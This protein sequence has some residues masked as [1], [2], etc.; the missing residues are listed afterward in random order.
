VLG[1]SPRRSFVKA[2]GGEGSVDV[3]DPSL[4]LDGGYDLIVSRTVAESVCAWSGY[5]F[6]PTCAG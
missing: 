2:P 1:M 5:T 3:T 6:T 4:E